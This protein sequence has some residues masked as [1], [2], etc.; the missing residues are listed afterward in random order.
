MSYVVKKMPLLRRWLSDSPATWFYSA[1]VSQCI[2]QEFHITNRLNNRIPRLKLCTIHRCYIRGNYSK[3]S[4][5]V[6]FEWLWRRR[7]IWYTA[8][9]SHVFWMIYGVRFVSICCKGP[10]VFDYHVQVPVYKLHIQKDFFGIFL[11]HYS[12]LPKCF[13]LGSIWR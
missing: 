1:G 7:I 10:M 5:H 3:K 11:Y 6:G 12:S 2:L 13:S 8:L 9:Y 4:L